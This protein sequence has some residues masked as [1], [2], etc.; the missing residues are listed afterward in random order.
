MLEEKF[1]LINVFSNFP[2]KVESF[3]DRFTQLALLK[4]NLLAERLCDLLNAGVGTIC[5]VFT[6]RFVAL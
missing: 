3:V 5:I 1:M 2:D 6:A 4:V